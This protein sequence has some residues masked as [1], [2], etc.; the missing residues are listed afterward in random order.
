MKIKFADGIDIE[1]DDEK[2]MWWQ[3]SADENIVALKMNENGHVVNYEIN[4]KEK[5]VFKVKYGSYIL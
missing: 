5:T 1:V 2:L 3:Q 4:L